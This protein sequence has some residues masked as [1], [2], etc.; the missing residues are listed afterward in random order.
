LVNVKRHLVSVVGRGQKNFNL[1]L[2]E[3]EIFIG[4]INGNGQR[5]IVCCIHREILAGHSYSKDD[6]TAHSV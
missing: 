3:I 1:G 2:I 6:N 4:H 5:A